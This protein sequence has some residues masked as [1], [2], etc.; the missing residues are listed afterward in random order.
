MKMFLTAVA[1][2]F[3]LA[4]SPASAAK[5]SKS[6]GADKPSATCPCSGSKLCRGPRGGT[7]CIAP[8]GKKRYQK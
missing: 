7:Y 2:M 5:K 1:T 6:A 8:N 3:L 4:A